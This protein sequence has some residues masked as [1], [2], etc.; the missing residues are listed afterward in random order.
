MPPTRQRSPLEAP[1]K[2]ASTLLRC[3]SQRDATRLDADKLAGSVWRDQRAVLLS[4][5]EGERK[6]LRSAALGLLAT[7]V[8]CSPVVARELLQEFE[9]GG[10]RVE[11]GLRDVEA[12]H[13]AVQ[14]LANIGLALL[15]TRERSVLLRLLNSEHKRLASAPLRLLPKL[16]AH[17]QVQIL[18]G[19]RSHVL[20]ASGLP[21]RAKLAPCLS[22]LEAVVE[23]YAARGAPADA[24]HA[25]LL[26]VLAHLLPAS[27]A[28]RVAHALRPTSTPTADGKHAGGTEAA[29]ASASD[30]A[31]ADADA[32]A[33]GGALAGARGV[34][35]GAHAPLSGAED[36]ALRA[37]LALRPA[38][39][40]RQLR[41]LLAALHALPS[42]RGPYVRLR[43]GAGSAPE[44]KPSRTWLAHLAF[45]CELCRV[46]LGSAADSA[47]HCA[48]AAAL[49][50]AVAAAGTGAP[51][52][53]PPPSA[54]AADAASAL[55]AR[56]PTDATAA[57]AV[58][59]A[60][61]PGAL[62][63][64]LWTRAL[65]HTSLLVR[66]SAA[67]ALLL[68][69]PRLRTLTAPLAA[70]AARASPDSPSAVGARLIAAEVHKRL[71]D[72]QVLPTRRSNPHPRPRPQPWPHP[73]RTPV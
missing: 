17:Q 70:A 34:V 68:V 52:S 60:L 2:A 59:D 62:G 13:S 3:L 55:A 4:C 53:L 12:S 43:A 65:L 56:P 35:H 1:F 37:L 40:G 25:H 30:G 46:T 51:S 58:L 28:G 29:V 27:I 72:V 69:L 8:G 63:R 64:S 9:R 67:N 22:T 32:D 44:P 5:V 45:V 41:L 11:R 66:V 36:A 7:L 38:S 14:H 10:S 33:D 23:L 21:L 18:V 15:R 31:G 24:A 19:V 61:F 54:P 50:V 49:G 39:D 47:S 42:L 57:A 26:L 73:P 20:L 6:P 16:P 48:D 71:P